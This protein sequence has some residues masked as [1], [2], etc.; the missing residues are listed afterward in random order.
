MMEEPTYRDMTTEPIGR[1]EEGT[2][3]AEAIMQIMMAMMAQMMGQ[4]AKPRFGNAQPFAPSGTPEG[5]PGEGR[6]TS[7]DGDY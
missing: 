2:P 3:E 7:M 5:Y 4:E 6:D 1:Y